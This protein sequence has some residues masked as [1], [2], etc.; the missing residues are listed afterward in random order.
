MGKLDARYFP[1]LFDVIDQSI[2]TVDRAGVITSFNHAAEVTTGYTANEVIG[3]ECREVLR[4]DLCDQACPL[5]RTLESGRKVVDRRV[6]IKTKDGR[7]LP[8]S[9]T[10]AVLATET[11]RVLGGVEVLTDL[12]PLEHLQRQLDGKHRFEDII[13][14]SPKMQ[15]IFDLLPMVANSDSTVLVLGES[16]TGKELLAKAIHHQSPRRNRPFVAVN[17]AAMPETLMESELFGYIR[18]AF[19]DAKRDKPGRI[20]Q[21]DGGTLFLDEVGDLPLS[22]QVKLLRFLQERAYEP[23][24]ATFTTRADVRIICATNRS[25]H[26]MVGSG[27]FRQDLYFRLNVM[28]IELPPL[29]ERIEDVPML[30]QHFVQRFRRTTGNRIDSLD[31]EAMSALMRYSFP[32]NIRELQNIVERAFIVC[33]EPK[34]GVA[35]LPGCVFDAAPLLADG[36]SER[37]L[38]PDPEQAHLAPIDQAERDTILSCLKRH[39]G[40]RSHAANELGIHRSTLI[41][42]IKKYGIVGMNLT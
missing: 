29:R 30:A 35:A 37:A 25:V 21:A 4:S 20:A 40:N 1:L 24:G 38:R 13:S 32:G 17:C 11:G 39:G 36:A 5:R 14:K 22:V 9:V 42:K 7:S 3:K 6:R 2:F 15:Q 27:A 23:L 8:V 18:G 12:S 19:T 10:T 31:D 16:G 34:I 26:E 33:R 28:Q 41:R